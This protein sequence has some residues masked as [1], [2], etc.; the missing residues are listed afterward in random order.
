MKI[1][2]KV[3]KPN[4]HEKVYF[5]GMRIFTYHKQIKIPDFRYEIMKYISVT[6][7]K[8]LENLVLGSSHGRDGFIPR[9]HDFN[10]SASSLDL[11]RIW[12]LYKYVAKNN[13]KNLKRI[14]VFWSVFHPG[15]QLE[16]T[17]QYIHC[18]PYKRFYG[19]DYAFPLPTDDTRALNALTK[20]VKSVVCPPN[21]RGKS[22]YIKD[23]D[24]PGDALVEKHIKNTTRNN[25]QIQFLDNVAKL[26][27]K[28]NHKLYIVLPPYRSDYL[29]CLPKQQIVFHE[30][31]EFLKKHPDVQLLNF[32]NDPD[33]T[34]FDF[35]SPD[36]LIE[37]GGEKLTKKICASIYKR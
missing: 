18:V 1:L 26:A 30:L 20:Q 29:N 27:Q 22:A 35:G 13:G 33:F 10:L 28:N 37:S 11:Y 36:H 34:D 32:Q 8:N 19:I 24:S 16:K 15:L 4:G 21:Y 31:F 5:L 7:C 3:C 25:N 14:I 9:K 12:N 23:I 17:R 6:Q 2:R